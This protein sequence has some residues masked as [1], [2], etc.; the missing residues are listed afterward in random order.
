MAYELK[1]GQGSLF[2][3]D[4]G[5]NEKKPDYEGKANIG[6]TVYR[7]AGWLKEGSKGKWLSLNIELPRAAQPA[8]GG[9][10][11]APTPIDDSGHSTW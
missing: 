8:G 2:R 1:D 10:R 4:K 3:A 11:E 5:G 7:I 9:K 6:G